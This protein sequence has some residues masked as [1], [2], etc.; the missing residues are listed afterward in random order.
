MGRP[1][2]CNPCCGDGSGGSS[3][4]IS[5]SSSGPS[6]PVTDGGW[7]PNSF[8]TLDPDQLPLAWTFTHDAF[9]GA[10]C[11]Q[12]VDWLHVYS[13]QSTGQIGAG[14][15]TT[16]QTVSID[17][18]L[19]LLKNYPLLRTTALGRWSTPAQVVSPFY[20]HTAAGVVIGNVVGI[21]KPPNAPFHNLQLGPLVSGT[22]LRV[23]CSYSNS[24]R[25]WT[26]GFSMTIPAGAHYRSQTALVGAGSLSNYPVYTLTRTGIGPVTDI[27]CAINQEQ[28]LS[29]V[30]LGGVT[31]AIPRNPAT[32]AASLNPDFPNSVTFPGTVTLTPYGNGAPGCPILPITGLPP[33]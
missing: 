6:W 14:G 17:C 32:C 1:Y 23:T 18:D 29:S 22:G 15:S 21:M 26:V 12:Q 27:Y 13:G 25:R 33:P 10:A 31:T 8:C 11:G 5:G 24:T 2:S 4:S 3:S 30:A 28:T 16:I 20:V 7:L 19:N 9:A